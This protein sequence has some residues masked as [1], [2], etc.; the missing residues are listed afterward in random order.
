MSLSDCDAR[1]CLVIR[2]QRTMYDWVPSSS[3]EEDPH[4]N[5]SLSDVDVI[6]E[7]SFSSLV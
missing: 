1:D 4:I 7:N 6:S 5:D 3:V 2:M